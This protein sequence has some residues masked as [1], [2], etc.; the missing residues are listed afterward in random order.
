MR[1]TEKKHSALWASLSKHFPKGHVIVVLGLAS[2][3]GLLAA[4]PSEDASANRRSETL[5]LPEITDRP[6]DNLP[7]EVDPLADVP[8]FSPA[9]P[10]LNIIEES[11]RSGDSLS[12]I[13]ARAGLNDRDMLEL[14]NTSDAGKQLNRLYPGH[15]LIFHIDDDKKLQKLEYVKNRLESHIFSRVDK[16][17]TDKNHIL[18]PDVHLALRQATI[19]NSLFLA[20][21]KV[22]LDDRLIMDLANIFGWDIDFALDIREGDSFKVL[23]EESFLDGEKIGNGAILAA[24]FT[25]QGHTFRAV[26][27]VDEDGDTHY[28]TPTGESM[29]K[30]FLRAPVDFRRISS[31]FNPRRLH[32]IHKTVRPHRGTDYAA[33]RGTPVWASGSG[34]VIESGYTRANGNYIV[35]QHGNNIQTKY[36]HLDKRYVKKGERVRQKQTIG[37]VG[38][39]GYSTA[40]HLH[41]EFVL[42][43]THRDPRTIIQ[44]LPKAQAVSQ[45][46]MARFQ[47]QTQPL[48]AELKGEADTRFAKTEQAESDQTL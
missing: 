17:F 9:E 37:T 5:V 36:L 42:D 18:E 11:V 40:P 41:Y 38:S 29:R 4:L 12:R 8:A 26:R 39:T 22:Q 16:G 45:K 47:A 46:E 2:G 7:N 24:E 43:G 23:F 21:Q 30:A 28:Y 34:R 27:Y 32:P 6:L 1:A 3:L 20:G 10:S 35:I 19:T 44:K 13:F 48:L 33:A 25:N 15:K 31:N 14:I